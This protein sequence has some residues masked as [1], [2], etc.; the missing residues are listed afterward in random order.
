MV[1]A[2]LLYGHC[3]S[4]TIQAPDFTRLYRFNRGR[5]QASSLVHSATADGL[6][7]SVLSLRESLREY[8]TAA[9]PLSIARLLLHLVLAEP[10]S[11]TTWQT[12]TS[13]PASCMGGKRATT[14][15]HI[16]RCAV[17]GTA[18]ASPLSVTSEQLQRTQPERFHLFTCQRGRGSCW[19]SLSGQ[20]LRG[21]P[22]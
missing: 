7:H 6:Q 21:R 16:E 19:G 22:P 5:L 8:R 3:G 18:S 17:V 12:K 15:F 14:P 13:P 20:V 10:I 1:V 4:S 2:T 9:S 11:T